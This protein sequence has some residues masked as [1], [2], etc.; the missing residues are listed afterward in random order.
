MSTDSIEAAYKKL[1]ELCDWDDED[2]TPGAWDECIAAARAYGLAVLDN[3]E[4]AALR[5]SSAEV[6]D[7]F[8]SDA[9]EPLRAR[10]AALGKETP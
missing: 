10:I 5:N 7:Q 8:V 9:I 6:N 4:G 1:S 2:A 3:V